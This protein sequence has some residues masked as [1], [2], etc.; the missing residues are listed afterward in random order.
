MRNL[1]LYSTNHGLEALH[2]LQE[3]KKCVIKDSNYRYHRRFTLR[4]INK[5][6]VPVSVELRS[7]NSKISYGVRK[8]IQK[9]EKQLLQG[10]V[11]CINVI[12][13]DNGEKLTRCRSRL[14]SLI[15]TTMN[16]DRCAEF[17]NKVRETRFIK[18]KNR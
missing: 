6:M 3:W 4:C 9:A 5:G 17:M 18:V 11:K 8:I 10:R 1:Q 16:K 14:L 12:L 2:L 7:T 15:T 13:Q